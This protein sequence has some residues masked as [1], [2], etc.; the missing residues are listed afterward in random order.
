MLTMQA[1][2]VNTANLY[3]CCLSRTFPGLLELTCVI[4]LYRRGYGVKLYLATQKDALYE[5]WN[6]EGMIDGALF[7]NLDEPEKACESLCKA[8][9]ESGIKFDGVFS[10]TE[11]WQPLVG[12]VC[13]PEALVAKLACL[14]YARR[15]VPENF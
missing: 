3:I 7:C 6:N 5:A 15:Y 10:R 8:A 9:R 12:Q 13:P 11:Q 2:F 1:A 4:R 14:V